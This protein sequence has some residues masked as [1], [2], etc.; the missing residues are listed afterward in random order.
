VVL[1]PDPVAEQRA[2][3]ERRGRVDREHAHPLAGRAQRGD[4]R[5]RRRRLADT[6]RAGES[7]DLCV[8]A[9]R[10]ERRRDLAQ[11]RRVV[12]DERDQ[13]GDRPRLTVASAPDELADVDIDVAPRNGQRARQADGTCS[14][15]A[16]P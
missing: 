9:V 5:R 1:H 15:S 13:P 7:D 6:G 3:R 12:L 8:P 10:R 11:H 14:T 4:H 2:T 16:S